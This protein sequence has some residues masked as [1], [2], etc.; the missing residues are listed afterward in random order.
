MIEIREKKPRGKGSIG[1]I[2]NR[3]NKST[4]TTNDLRDVWNKIEPDVK[5][6]IKFEFSKAN[7]NKW[8]SLKPEYKAWKAR[9]GYPITIGVMTGALK[10]AASD[11]A[12]IK[13]KR[14]EFLLTVN[15]NVAGYKGKKVGAYA[16][17]FDSKR[18]MF[19]HTKNFINKIYKE[20]VRITLDWASR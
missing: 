19:G 17:Y 8:S 15:P 13:K 6:S 20:A 5:D 14:K 18:P 4:K 12:K 2:I 9:K 1:Y 11:N 16:H 3:I 7:P 10:S